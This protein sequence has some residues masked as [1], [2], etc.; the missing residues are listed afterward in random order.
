MSQ[1]F[2]LDARLHAEAEARLATLQRLLADRRHDM[3]VTTGRL[4]TVV[5][6]TEN[7]GDLLVRVMYTRIADRLY[8]LVVRA[9]VGLIDVAW[10]DKDKS[11]RGLTAVLTKKKREREAIDQEFMRESGALDRR[12]KRV[13]EVLG[14]LAADPN[15]PGA[16][17]AAH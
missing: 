11:T 13:M 5:R 2:A 9:D 17:P 4:A 7:L 6:D 14:Q 3:A 1:L 15:L 8:D 16:H 12:L 10:A